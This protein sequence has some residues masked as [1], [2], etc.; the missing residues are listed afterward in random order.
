MNAQPNF[1]V[2]GVAKGGT[3]SLHHY[4]SQHP[5]VYLTPIKE[6][7]YF[8]SD[9][10]DEQNLHPVYRKDIHLDL[11]A[12]IEQGMKRMVHIAHVRSKQ[13]YQA[14]YS[15]ASN[16][17]AIGEIS[18]SYIICPSAMSK[19]KAQFPEAKLI[20]LLRN[21]IDR[22]WSHFLMNVRESKTT[23]HDFLSEVNADFSLNKRGW[24]V[25]HQYIELGL[26][27]NQVKRVLANF[28]KHQIKWLLFE[29]F[30]KNTPRSLKEICSFLNVDDNFEFDLSEKA[31]TAGVPR[32]REVN[33]LLVDSGLVHKLKAIANPKQKAWVKS[34]LLKQGAAIPKIKDSERDRIKEY[35]EKDVYVLS[36]LLEFDF[37]TTWNIG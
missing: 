2:I 32:N 7:N 4:L 14:L 17:K 33:K 34:I 9:D 21:P 30:K 15:K 6:T 1:F 13:H 26:Y 37:N 25:S 11:E 19:I 28:S 23:H 12:Y 31:N 22:A 36:Q 10:I 18:N 3:T 8:A 35:Y 16:E 27:A 5:E 24:G 20:F 29:D